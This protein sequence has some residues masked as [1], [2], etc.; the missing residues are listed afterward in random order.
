MVALALTFLALGAAWL[1]DSARSVSPVPV[2]ET[3]SAWTPS[4][5]ANLR[6]V[7]ASWLQDA[8]DDPEESIAV[9]DLSSQS[10]YELEHVP[11]AVHGW[12]QDGMDPHARVYG[13][14][15]FPT[16]DPAG[17]ATW[18]ASLGIQP[19]DKVVAYDNVRNQHAARLVWLLA[20][21]GFDDAVIFDGGL[22]AWKGAGFTTATGA[23]G[24]V[25]AQPEIT[26]HGELAVIE[27]DELND[28][29]ADDDSEFELLDMR[30]TD[31]LDET[32]NGTRPIGRIPGSTWIS[33]DLFHQPDS[34]LLRAPDGIAAMLSDRGIY[35]GDAVVIYGQFGIDTGLPWLVLD[36]LGYD[37][38][39]IYDQGW[40]TWASDPSRPVEP[41]TESIPPDGKS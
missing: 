11:G 4:Q 1:V 17:L 30:A 39:R 7:N 6:I 40:V 33:I 15:Y 37:D 13:E 18:F 21:A 41:I 34:G 20:N 31:E 19:G 38:I 9:V 3:P 25:S 23:P 26:G 29:V 2:E 35:P 16:T 32:L 14:R 8:L 22:A 36:A 10:R 24:P 28:V 12:W 5:Q 27:T